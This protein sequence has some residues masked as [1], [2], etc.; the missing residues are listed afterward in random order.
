MW[1]PAAPGN[2][3]ADGCANRI[4]LRD[5]TICILFVHLLCLA[6]ACP[7]PKRVESNL[8]RVDDATVRVGTGPE[9][10]WG[11]AESAPK[12]QLERCQRLRELFEMVGCHVIEPPNGTA[13]SA[14]SNSL[15]CRLQGRSSK[16]ILV[17]SDFE[18]SAWMKRDG[19]PAANFLPG[20]Y[21]ALSIEERKH[22]FVFLA[23]DRI[24]GARGGMRSRADFRIAAAEYPDDIAAV[25]NIRAMGRRVFG[26]VTDRAD[27]TLYH[28]LK[29]VGNSLK[30]PVELSRAPRHDRYPTEDSTTLVRS[31]GSP[32]PAI[33][34]AIAD[35]HTSSYLDS[36]RTLAVYLAYI[37]RR[38][39]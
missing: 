1:S 34:L 22:S 39:H 18:E 28:D 29:R 16:S 26:V 4:P 2:S 8:T 12:N 31:D 14:E 9:Y 36:F 6:I 20:L 21:S 7:A 17:V 32:I 35:F 15:I 23:S 24:R 30:I 27:R 5:V 13:V 33:S 25:V 38:D 11:D 19:W 37:D 3:R 10:L